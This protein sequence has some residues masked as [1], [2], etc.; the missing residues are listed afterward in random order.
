MTAATN[1][2]MITAMV[3]ARVS[4][5]LG[6]LTLR[7]SSAISIDTRWVLG[8]RQTTTA[9]TTAARNPRT[10][11]SVQSLTTTKSFTPAAAKE[12][13]STFSRNIPTAKAAAT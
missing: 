10:V 13:S 8:T 1:D 3:E 4:R 11:E 5:T 7:S 9:A 6:Q 2:A 12:I